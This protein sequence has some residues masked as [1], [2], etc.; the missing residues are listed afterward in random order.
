MQHDPR[1]HIHR[2]G[3]AVRRL[4]SLTTGT[5]VVGIAGTAAF[6]AVSAASWSGDPAATPLPVNATTDSGSSRTGT[7]P[8]TPRTG[9]QQVV[10]NG[11]FAQPPTVTGR[12]NRGTGHASS[13]GSH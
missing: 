11:G 13:G 12:V 5:A 3:I 9:V 6:G 4:R 7:T 10:P 1:P 2:R 8:T